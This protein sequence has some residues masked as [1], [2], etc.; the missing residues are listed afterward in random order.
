LIFGDGLGQGIDGLDVEV[1]GRFV[2]D[3]NVRGGEGEFGESDPRLLSAGQVLHGDGVGVRGQAE[4]SEL[5]P[6]LESILLKWVI[7]IMK[8]IRTADE[9]VEA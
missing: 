9:N 6:R 1:V 8:L 3:D 5:L 7:A 4:R 2:E